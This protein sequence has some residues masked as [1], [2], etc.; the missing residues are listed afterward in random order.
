MRVM[1]DNRVYTFRLQLRALNL[2]IN[3]LTCYCNFCD[4]NKSIRVN[5]HSK[6]VLNKYLICVG[7]QHR[8]RKMKN[9][10][11]I[12]ID[13]KNVYSSESASDT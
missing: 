12:A 1:L 13:I 11:F 6:I 3:H 5:T 4:L 9:R 7:E 10:K 2:L 8:F